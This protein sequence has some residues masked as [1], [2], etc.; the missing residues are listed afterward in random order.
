ME[1]EFVYKICNKSEWLE[2]KQNKKFISMY[3]KNTPLKR[4]MKK[5]ELNHLIKFLCTENSS[6][7]TGSTFVIDGGYTSW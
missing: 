7:A 2:A 1:F 6:Y 4:M 3:S 5:N